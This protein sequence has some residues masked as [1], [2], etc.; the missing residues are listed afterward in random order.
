MYNELS[1]TITHKDSLITPVHTAVTGRA[2]YKV[3]GLYGNKAL[4]K[5]LESQLSQ[6]RA[7]ERVQAN[8]DTGNIL[9]FYHP[10]WSQS[11]IA[12]LIQQI[13]SSYSMDVS[14][15][16]PAQ[17]VDLE[18]EVEVGESTKVLI[19]TAVGAVG[20][21]AVCTLLVYARGLDERVLL[22]IQKLHSPLLDTVMVG[23][24]LFGEGVTL[25]LVSGLYRHWLLRHNRRRDANTLMVAA[26]GGI[27]LNC[28]LKLLFARSR[29]LLWDRIVEVSHH[30]FPSGHSMV[31]MIVYGYIGYTLAKQ[32]PQYRNQISA[33]AV[34]FIM[35]IG[36]SRLYLGV[37]WL[38][39]VTAGYA[40]GLVWLTACILFNVKST[41]VESSIQTNYSVP[42]LAGQFQN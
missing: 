38:T 30:S 8:S 16:V 32:Y 35:T 22:T 19:T 12:G 1:R 4:K 2:R 13:V 9:V 18:R 33:L 28:L 26:F 11:A 42:V 37:H 23:V 14:Y 41:P 39:D 7:I 29:P 24:T 17:V 10:N 5:Y 3:Y 27:G 36:F 31:S 40:A 15:T 21:L 25:L 20:V 6:H 34:A